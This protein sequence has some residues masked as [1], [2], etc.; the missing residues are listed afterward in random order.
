M[1][2]LA[3]SKLQQDAF[4]LSDSKDFEAWRLKMIKESP[5]FHYWDLILKTEVQVLTFIRAHQERNFPLYIESLESLVNIFLALDHYNYSRWVSIHLRDK[6]S[7]PDCAK[8]TFCQN[9]VLQK[10]TNRFSAIP[11]DQAHEQENAKV[12]GKGGVVELT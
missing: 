5:T 2:A 4:T 12:K 3:L 7:L 11:L 8:V 6:K 1:T 9:W 10:T